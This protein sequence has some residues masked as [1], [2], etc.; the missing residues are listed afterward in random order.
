MQRNRLPSRCLKGD[1]KL[2]IR[3]DGTVLPEVPNLSHEFAFG[4]TIET[5]TIVRDWRSA[6]EAVSAALTG[7]QA[8]PL[9]RMTLAQGARDAVAAYEAHRQ[10]IAKLSSALRRANAAIR[11]TKEQAAAGLTLQLDH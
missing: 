6:R 7:K 9:E 4:N 2:V 3:E 8:A 1:H 10:G 5:A 11:V